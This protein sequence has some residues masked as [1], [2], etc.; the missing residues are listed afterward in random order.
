[1]INIPLK[2]KPILKEKIWGGTKLA[3]LL[4]KQTL[5]N[6]V[7]ESWEIADV[8]NDV[9]IVLDGKYQGET[10]T[11]LINKYKSSF[12]GKKAYQSFGNKFP[13]LIKFIEAKDDLS[14]QLHPNDEYAIKNEESFGKSE[15]WYIMQA[16]DDAQLIIGFKEQVNSKTYQKHL[17]EKTL[18]KILNSEHVKEG[19]VYFIPPGRVHAIRSG[20]LLAEIQQA[21]DIT[22][23]IYDWN[24]K[25]KNGI[26]RELHTK[27]AL[28]VI[29]FEVKDYYKTKYQIKENQASLMI[30]CPFF[31]TNIIEVEGKI[32]VNHF[33]KDSFV[34]YLCV[35]GNVIFA[36]NDFEIKLNYG[37]TLLIPNSLNKFE[38]RSNNKSK[39]LEVFIE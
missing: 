23:R 21:S 28:E 35:S 31:T 24:R 8:D 25:D 7:G 15:M 26:G 39:L 33:N 6:N 18:L 27:K 3:N 38:I 36:N 11:T 16:D 9:S 5:S 37:E 34:I 29:D 2:F 14:I 17:K 1:M 20:V 12:V 13:L 19:D 30:K 10:L 4:N 22:Y 32:N